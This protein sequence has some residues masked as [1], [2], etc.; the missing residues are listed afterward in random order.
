[1]ETT[2]ALSPIL[3][4]GLIFLFLTYYIASWVLSTLI[5]EC[6]V[7]RRILR[8]AYIPLVIVGIICGA[9]FYFKCAQGPLVIKAFLITVGLC[10][11]GA[12][13]FSIWLQHGGGREMLY[14]PIA[15]ARFGINNRHEV[16]YAVADLASGKPD[17][18]R[19]FILSLLPALFAIMTIILLIWETS[20]P[21]SS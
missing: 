13:L 5:G 15:F 16:T 7:R 14:V 3:R 2:E 10:I 19:D 8:W 1:M 6:E 17:F 9:C 21:L 20:R 12:I 4:Y 18:R 11:G